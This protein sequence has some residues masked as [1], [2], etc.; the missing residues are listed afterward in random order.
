MEAIKKLSHRVTIILVAHRLET[1]RQ[2]DAI[3][4]LQDG[5]LAA[6][7]KYESL[8]EKSSLFRKMAKS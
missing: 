4:L 3:Y 7:G 1:V 5:Q 8:L 2:C 6:C